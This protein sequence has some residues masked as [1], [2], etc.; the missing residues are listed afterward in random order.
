MSITGSDVDVA[1][2]DGSG[3]I[4]CN[5]SI[6]LG[7]HLLFVILGAERRENQTAWRLNLFHQTKNRLDYYSKQTL[8]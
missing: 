7:V 1:G 8:E 2:D 5:A 4:A 6:E 3:R